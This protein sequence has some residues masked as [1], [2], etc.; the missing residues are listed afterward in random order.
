MRERTMEATMLRITDSG[1]E[2]LS[3]DGWQEMGPDNIVEIPGGNCIQVNAE[4]YWSGFFQGLAGGV[5]VALFT[6][7]IVA[8]SS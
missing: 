8:A 6:L 7:G 4:S 2:R 3:S 1:I 5:L